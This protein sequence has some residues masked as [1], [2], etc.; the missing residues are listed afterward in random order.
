MIISPSVSF[1]T[2]R[3]TVKLC[4]MQPVMQHVRLC[5]KNTAHLSTQTTRRST[6]TFIKRLQKPLFFC[7]RS[8]VQ[9]QTRNLIDHLPSIHRLLVFLPPFEDQH[10][11]RFLVGD[12]PVGLEFL[13]NGIADIRRR[14]VESVEGAY[15]RS[16]RGHMS[17]KKRPWW[18]GE[19][20][21]DATVPVSV[22]LQ[23]T[24]S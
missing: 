15:F 11:D 3:S 16:L 7:N 12:V 20:E 2:L 6:L 24:L 10:V 23:H 14:V 5:L 22:Q 19:T 13:S 9:Q 4:Q 17:F 21:T 1:Y 8:G 18:I